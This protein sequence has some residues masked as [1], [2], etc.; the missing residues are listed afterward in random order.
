MDK[1][2][3]AAFFIREEDK[4]NRLY[5]LMVKNLSNEVAD[6]SIQ[7]TLLDM[8]GYAILT[9]IYLATKSKSKI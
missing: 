9:K 7:D 6:E 2:G 3:V 5:T 8:A 4:L 1:Y